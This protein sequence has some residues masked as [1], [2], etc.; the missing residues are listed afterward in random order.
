M[1]DLLNPPSDLSAPP[2]LPPLSA[3]EAVAGTFTKPAE[4]FERLLSRSTWWLPFVLSLL[5]SALAGYVIAPKL[6]FDG[7]A[8]EAVEK[9]TAKTGGTASRAQIDQ[10]AQIMKKFGSP[11]LAASFGVVGATFV[12]FFVAVVVWGAAR[13]FGSTVDFVPALST[14]GHA[15]LVNVVGGVFGILIL[16]PIENASILQ[17]S[18]PRLIKTNVGAFLPESVSDIAVALFSVLDV[19]TLA[20]TA[21]LV[22]ALRRFPGLPQSSAKAIPWV[23]LFILALFKAAMTGLGALMS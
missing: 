10:T 9:R 19:F 21:L 5:V 23:L 14:W 3:F 1:S 12:F 4:T 16:L 15:N 17:K 6:D 8:R 22:V 13:A 11:L 2:R 7:M 20:T 18:L